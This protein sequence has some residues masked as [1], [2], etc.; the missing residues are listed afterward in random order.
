MRVGFV[1]LGRLGSQLVD[2]LVAAGHESLT[3]FD[4][5][6]EALARF[7][8]RDAT[9]AAS[10]AEVGAA[11]SDVVGVCVQ[12]DAQLRDVVTG[13][14]GLLSAPMTEGAVIAVHST[15]HPTTCRGL[16]KEAEALGVTLID[17][18]ISNGGRMPGGT[19]TRVVV[20]GSDTAAFER[21]LPYF[22]GFGDLVE[23]AGPLGSGEVVKLLNNLLMIVN[24]GMAA[25]AIRCGEKLGVSRDVVVRALS[26]GSGSS[27]GIRTLLGE[28]RAAHNTIL[29]GK[30]FALALDVLSSGACDA[31]A[32]RSGGA[33]GLVALEAS[34]ARYAQAAGSSKG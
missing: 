32:L 24:M 14:G 1:G 6:S 11:A 26:T 20:V 22:E 12:N 21:C 18:A 27:Q 15:V 19:P 17:A 28:E 33:S 16:A 34:A 13:S 31:E 23:H 10:V 5:S 3:L 2:G 8:D 30:D 29:L 25:E 7:A 9:L 4:V